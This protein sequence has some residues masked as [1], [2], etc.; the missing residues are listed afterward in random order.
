MICLVLLVAGVKRSIVGPKLG[1]PYLSHNSSGFSNYA[2]ALL[3][4]LFSF[5]GW[6]NA[7]FVSH[8]YLYHW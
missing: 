2:Q 4:V 5:E 7:N 1:F 8:P 6:E 3:L